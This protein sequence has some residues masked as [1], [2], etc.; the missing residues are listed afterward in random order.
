MKQRRD[1]KRMKNDGRKIELEENRKKEDQEHELRM[2]RML[3]QM[4]QGVG[5][6]RQYEFDYDI[7]PQHDSCNRL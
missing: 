5:Y 4:F 1:I 6:H 2:M 3:G 7:T